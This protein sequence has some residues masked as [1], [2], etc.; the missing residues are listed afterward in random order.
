MSAPMTLMGPEAD[1]L[2]PLRPA[3]CRGE[4]FSSWLVRLA[5]CYEMPVRV[6][7][8]NVWPDREVWRGD[9]DRQIDDEALELLSRN[10]GVPYSELFSMT[11]RA[12][13]KW[14]G[15]SPG[16]ESA[17][18]LYFHYGKKDIGIRFCPGCLVERPAYFRLDWRLAFITVCSRHRIPL[19]ERCEYCKSPC[20]FAKADVDD[21][22]GSCHYCGKWFSAMGKEV[23][24]DAALHIDLHLEFQQNM[25]DL[26][27]KRRR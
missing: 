4:L 15:V 13:E 24:K 8:R 3:P 16:D 10:T 27:R 20:L 11:L 2:W 9:I 14:A 22:L 12:H 17:K 6:F 21:F 7:C 23:A 26:M 18:E 5:R 1:E 25:L 19:L